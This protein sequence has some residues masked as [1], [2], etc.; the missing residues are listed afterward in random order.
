MGKRNVKEGSDL[1]L[2]GRCADNTQLKIPGEDTFSYA[3]VF[4]GCQD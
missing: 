4:P 2:L 1:T 3:P